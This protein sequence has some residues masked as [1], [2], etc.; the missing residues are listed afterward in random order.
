MKLYRCR[1]KGCKV[2]LTESEVIA[3]RPYYN[4]FHQMCP[5]CRDKISASAEKA[6]E[7][8]AYKLRSSGQYDNG[9]I[10]GMKN[11]FRDQI[12]KRG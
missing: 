10:E 5:S 3:L 4:A 9:T 6:A 11:N 7:S 1:G 8:Y 12:L 2:Q